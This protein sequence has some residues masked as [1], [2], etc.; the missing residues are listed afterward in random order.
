[1][2]M[3]LLLLGAQCLEQ[4]RM[5]KCFS[6]KFEISV[7]P[8]FFPSNFHA[9]ICLEDISIE[10]QKYSRWYDYAFKGPIFCKKNRPAVSTNN[11]SRE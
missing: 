8:C 11:L 6:P 7:C 10:S 9:V 5:K 4:T 1:M 3:R 2:L